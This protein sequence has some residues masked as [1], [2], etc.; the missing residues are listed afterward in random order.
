MK[1]IRTIKKYEYQFDDSVKVLITPDLNS[2]E[3]IKDGVH[4]R[5]FYL[6]QNDE[7]WQMAGCDKVHYHVLL[8]LREY[9]YKV[10]YLP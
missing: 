5:G 4:L 1:I 6:E 9:G 7:I 10:I 3:W 2:W 8:A